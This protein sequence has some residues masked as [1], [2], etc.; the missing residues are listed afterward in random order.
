MGL[1]ETAVH[2]KRTFGLRLPENSSITISISQG[3]CE[4]DEH[5]THVIYDAAGN[6][7]L[8][9]SGG[10]NTYSQDQAGAA[11]WYRVNLTARGLLEGEDQE[12]VV[13]EKQIPFLPTSIRIFVGSQK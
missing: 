8:M 10:G 4:W 3:E 6:R 5:W 2:E 11:D 12:R 1:L 7:K 9:G 13:L